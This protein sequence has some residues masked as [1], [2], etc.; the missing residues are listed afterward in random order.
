[1]DYIHSGHEKTERDIFIFVFLPLIL[2]FIR[3]DIRGLDVSE[4]L[5][6]AHVWEFFQIFLTLRK[7]FKAKSFKSLNFALLPQFLPQ[8]F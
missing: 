3:E 8:N 2:L 4:Q 5:G 7:S 6:S 1:M